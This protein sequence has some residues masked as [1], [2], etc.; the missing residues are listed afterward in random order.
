[1]KFRNV[2]TGA[3]VETVCVISGTDWEA[4]DSASL[5]GSGG[6]QGW[7]DDDMNPVVIPEG[8]YPAE[9]VKTTA[10]KKVAGRAAKTKG[11]ENVAGSKAASS[12][13]AGAGK[14]G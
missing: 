9:D 5:A 7:R 4:V 13:K 6:Q 1:M 10:G 11:S 8:G 12:K 3:V 2:K 14:K